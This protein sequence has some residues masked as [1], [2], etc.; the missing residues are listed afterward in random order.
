HRGEAAVQHLY[1]VAAGLNSLVIGETQIQGQVKRAL[2]TAV[3]CGASGTVL[4]KVAQ[5]ALAAGK[6]VRF[7]TGMSDK[8]VSVSSAAV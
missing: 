2:Q 1:R 7:E 4:N 8:V 5:G 3:Q 6:R